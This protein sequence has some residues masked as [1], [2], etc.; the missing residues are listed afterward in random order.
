MGSGQNLLRKFIDPFD[1]EDIGELPFRC[2]GMRKMSKEEEK[3][4]PRIVVDSVM[5]QFYHTAR[6]E[7]CNGCDFAV[8]GCERVFD[9]SAG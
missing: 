5:C 9:M 1:E 3:K 6:F 7:R 2:K 4:F 8:A